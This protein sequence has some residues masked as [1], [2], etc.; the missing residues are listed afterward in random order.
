MP[1]G[2]VLTVL[3]SH[4]LASTG[5]VFPPPNGRQLLTAS[6]DSSLILWEISS[7]SP[8]FKLSVF[9]PPN[10]PELDPALHGIT[11]LAVSPNG[12]LAAVGGAAGLVKLVSLPK[13][14]VVATLNGHTEGESIEG[15]TFID[16]LQGQG[17]G[18]GV[19]LV[20]VST[21]GKGLV[22]DTA[23]GRIRAELK[24]DE[25]ITSL[26]AHQAPFL[27]LLTTGSADAVAKTWDVRT[28]QLVAEHKGHAGVINGV[29][30]AP[31]PAA[32]KEAEE[33]GLAVISA[34]DDGASLVWRL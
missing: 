13:G 4:T 12:Q 2:E 26:A 3:S 17:G 19:V 7:S 29:A 33:K 32:L 5:G 16:L 14:D 18:K 8:V 22:W 20:S 6:L 25:P 27:H 31:L 30:V 21:D 11:A 34:G 24:H 10:A 9:A 1:Q 23:T 28:G 15:L